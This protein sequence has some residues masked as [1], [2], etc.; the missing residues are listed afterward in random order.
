MPS[1]GGS[2]N[3]EGALKSQF[4]AMR[5]AEDSQDVI[6]ADSTM[7][8][9]ESLGV[10]LEDASFF[11]ALEAIQAEGIGEMKRDDFVKGWKDNNV[12]ANVTAQRAYIKSV[13][14]S[15]RTS[16]ETFRRVYRYAFTAAKEQN[17]RALDVENAIIYWSVLFTAPGRSW[18]S[19]GTGINF[20]PLW[21]QFLEEK[22]N[23]SVNKDM[24]NQTLEFAN[25]SMED[26]T[27]GFWSED[28]SWPGVIDDFVMWYRE[29]QP[30]ADAMD[31][32][33]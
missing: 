22:W 29:K 20:L 21:T 6:G 17:K 7:K 32:D 4:D 30:K 2:F 18:I 33:A 19:K 24:W 28:A 27:L 5:S 26:E 23:R 16:P 15:L 10:N 13:V 3:R 31:V 1:D 8:Y 12:G 25:K 9:L 14:S 11:V